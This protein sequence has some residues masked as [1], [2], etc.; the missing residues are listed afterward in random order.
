MSTPI[1]RLSLQLFDFRANRFFRLTESLLQTAKELVVLSLR[2][3]KIIIGQL[4]VFLLQFPLHFVP[5]AF[6]F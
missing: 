1:V 2:E 3:R 6:E 5:T 4:T